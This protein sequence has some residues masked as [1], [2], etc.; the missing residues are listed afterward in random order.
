MKLALGTVQFGLDYGV[1]NQAGRVSVN[2]AKNI[3]QRAALSGINTLDTA[4]GYGCSECTL[5]KVGVAGWHVITKL[6]PLPIDCQAVAAWVKAQIEQSMLRLGV[7]QLQA[8]LLHRPDDLL[9]DSGKS[10]VKVL[11]GLKADGVVRQIGVSIYAP[12]QLKALTSIMHPDL[13]QAPLNI[14]DRRLVD[15]GWAGRLKDQG[16]EIHTRSAFLQGLLL[17][18]ATQRPVKFTQWDAVWSEWSRWLTGTGLTPLQACLAYVLGITEVDRVVVGVDSLVHLDEILEASHFALP[19]L[20]NWP[21]SIDARLINPA[22]W[23]QL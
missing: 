21:Q 1:A 8:V 4:I 2:D 9:G 22:L 18:S 19:S 13:V 17:M 7:Q 14:L 15:S 16:A 3:I 6:P 20:P 10:L 23:S 12:E 11:D 5:G